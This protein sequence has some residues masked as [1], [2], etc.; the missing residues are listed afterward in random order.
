[1]TVPRPPWATRA[2]RGTAQG[3]PVRH[4]RPDGNAVS[5]EDQLAKVADTAGTQELVT[6]LY[7]KYHAMFRTALGRGG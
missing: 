5:M 3:P 6:N 2:G 7:R 1:M 4:V